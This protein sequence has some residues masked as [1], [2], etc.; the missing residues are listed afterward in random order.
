MGV[1]LDFGFSRREAEVLR[2]AAAGLTDKEIAARFGVSITTVRSFWD[3]IRRKTG[4][5]SRTHATVMAVK[6]GAVDED[7]L[8]SA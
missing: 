3:R 5:L 2:L 1:P 7:S 6:S 8:R 4:A